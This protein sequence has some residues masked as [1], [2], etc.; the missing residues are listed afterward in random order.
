MVEDYEDMTDQLED[1][2]YS[3]DTFLDDGYA[4]AGE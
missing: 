1:E 2:G 3:P 4:A